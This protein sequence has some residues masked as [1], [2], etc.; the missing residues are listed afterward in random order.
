MYVLSLSFLILVPFLF[1][2]CVYVSPF[3]MVAAVSNITDSNTKF[4]FFM[5]HQAAGCRPSRSRRG[6]WCCCRSGFAEERKMR[7][8]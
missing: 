6:G 4:S 7:C 5:L 3:F 1:H 2:G 8:H